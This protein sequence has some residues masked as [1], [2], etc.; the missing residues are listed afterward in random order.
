MQ[1]HR[2]SLYSISNKCRVALYSVLNKKKCR[3]S[4]YLEFGIKNIHCELHMVI[5][6][7]KNKSRLNLYSVMTIVGEDFYG[8]AEPQTGTWPLYYR[9][10]HDN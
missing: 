7:I 10:S 4:L 2:L 1:T 5:Y 3:L 8:V 9:K 6:C